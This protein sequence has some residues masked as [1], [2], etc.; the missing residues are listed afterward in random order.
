MNKGGE[1]TSFRRFRVDIERHVSICPRVDDGD[2]TRGAGSLQAP[3]K[4]GDGQLAPSKTMGNFPCPVQ[5]PDLPGRGSMENKGR[6]PALTAGQAIDKLADQFTS[7]TLHVCQCHHRR[8][9]ARARMDMNSRG[10][11][12]SS[13]VRKS[14]VSRA[15]EQRMAPAICATATCCLAITSLHLFAHFCDETAALFFLGRSKPLIGCRCVWA[16]RPCRTRQASR[17]ST[18]PIRHTHLALF[19]PRKCRAVWGPALRR[20]LLPCCRVLGIGCPES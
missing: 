8:G 11:R 2:W 19:D 7:C 5:E 9:R 17:Y 10:K 20:W 14:Q 16:V 12:V 18:S 15:R 6:G 13:V 3:I 4:S 1:I